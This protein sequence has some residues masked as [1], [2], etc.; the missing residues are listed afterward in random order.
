MN[1]DHVRLYSMV[2]IGDNEGSLTMTK[3]TFG[4][5]SMQ[6]QHDTKNIRC[7]KSSVAKRFAAQFT[8]N[9]ENK[10]YLDLLEKSAIDKTKPAMAGYVIIVPSYGTLMLVQVVQQKW[11]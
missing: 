5:R 7:Q 11:G 8:G 6:Y 4:K 3:K 9:R 2:N 10:L 1:T